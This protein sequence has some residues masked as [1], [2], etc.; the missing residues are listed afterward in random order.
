M[1]DG[2]VLVW[3]DLHL[4]H[5]NVIGYAN[6]PFADVTEMDRHLWAGWEAAARPDGVLLCVGD[7]AMRTALEE[8]T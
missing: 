8:G 4:G 3:S 5:A 2:R 1:E 7:L 6:R